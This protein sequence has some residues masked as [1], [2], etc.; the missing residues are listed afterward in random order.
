[1]RR[2]ADIPG[3]NKNKSKTEKQYIDKES[4]NYTPPKKKRKKRN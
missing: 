4:S 1:M 2:T 3:L